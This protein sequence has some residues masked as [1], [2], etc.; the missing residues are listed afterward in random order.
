MV[1]EHNSVDWHTG[2]EWKALL[3]IYDE[4]VEKY[5]SYCKHELVPT[6]F[7]KT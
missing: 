7:G 6:R 5:F 4:R 1:L 3:D 2:P